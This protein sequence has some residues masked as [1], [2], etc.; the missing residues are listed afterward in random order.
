VNIPSDTDIAILGGGLAGLTLALQLRRQ[1]PGMGITVLERSGSL[2]P[3][4]AHKVGESVVEIGAHYLSEVLGL[5]QLLDQTQLPKFG[6]R[7]FFGGNSLADFS[8]ADELGARTPLPVHTYQLDRGLLE[9]DLAR[10]AAEQDIRVIR[11]VTVKRVDLHRDG[12]SHRVE[13]WSGGE[14]GSISCCWVV[15][16][17]ARAAILKRK[18]GLE[19]PSPHSI[20]SVWFRLDQAI[21][22]DDFSDNREWKARTDIG[23]KLSTNQFMGSGYWTWLIPLVGDRTS[24][25]IVADPA[26]HALEDFGTFPRSLEWLGRRQPHFAEAIADRSGSLMDFR[27]LKHFS[28]DSEQ[29]WSPERWAQTG[30][31]GVFADPLYSPGTDFIAIG[32]TFITQLIA[33]Q[34]QGRSIRAESLIFNQLYKSFFA[35]TMSIYQGLYAGFG[36]RRLMVLKSTWDYAY[37]WGV[38][39]FLFFRRCMTDLPLMNELESR[40]FRLQQINR[41]MQACFRAVASG[42]ME[43]PGSGIFFDQCAIPMLIQLNGELLEHGRSVRQDLDRNADR[44]ERLASALKTE[45]ESGPADAIF[46]CELL[47]D[48]RYRLRGG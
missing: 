45:L 20:N 18:L 31:A 41:Q 9:G 26:Q 25:G 6:L 23:R 36:D 3:A 32:N 43:F 10:L 12:R 13:F 28:H 42:G 46:E 30:E 33:R 8:E 24:V 5:E 38:L 37:Y 15:D 27:F 4:A 34:S 48:L 44:L 7:F 19:K 17:A 16:A 22:V 35:N 21:D 40:L 47:G 29:L 2:P 39:A 1:D 11:G 14:P